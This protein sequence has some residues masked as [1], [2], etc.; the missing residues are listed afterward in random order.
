MGTAM[1]TALAH[2]EL[3][4][5][6]STEL[7]D[8]VAAARPPLESFARQLTEATEANP[9]AAT[10]ASAVE[11]AGWP[12]Q[13]ARQQLTDA[14]RSNPSSSPSPPAQTGPKSTALWCNALGP[15]RCPLC[16]RNP[17]PT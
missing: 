6:P 1:S 17:R 11:A 10:V 5:S 4:R 3:D 12:S 2:Y 14:A 13:A 16:P 8:R 9:D 7:L 15:P